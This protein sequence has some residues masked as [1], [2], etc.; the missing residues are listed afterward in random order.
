MVLHSNIWLCSS[1]PK[2]VLYMSSWAWFLCH[3]V[4]SVVFSVMLGV[5]GN[6]TFIVD[7][8]YNIVLKLCLVGKLFALLTRLAWK[9]NTPFQLVET[10]V[11]VSFDGPRH[12]TGFSSVSYYKI[13]HYFL[14][15]FCKAF[16]MK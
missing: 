13:Q 8:I 3:H 7:G 10:P 9:Q 14:A 16:G 1:S 15:L 4:C 11:M 5:V 12:G 6:G 2:F